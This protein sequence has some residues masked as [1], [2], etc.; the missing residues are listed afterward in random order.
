[1]GQANSVTRADLYRALWTE[2]TNKVAKNYGIS[3]VGL[4][5]ICRK[6]DIPRPPR[7]YWAQRQHGHEPEQIPLPKPE[8]NPSIDIH[9]SP[10]R[11]DVTE[12]LGA[13]VDIN[14]L[15]I[16]VSDTLRGCHELTSR[17][18][19][20]VQ[21]AKIDADG[22]IVPSEMKAMDIRTSKDNARRALLI[23]D[24]ILKE[25]LRHEYTVSAGPTVNIEQHAMKLGIH[26]IVDTKRE[27]DDKVDLGKPYEFG[28]SRHTTSR[29]PS[30]RLVLEITEGRGYWATGGRRSWRDSDKRQLE[31]QL[32]KVFLGLVETAAMARRHAEE[33]KQREEQ[34]QQEEARREEA[35]RQRAERYKQYRTEKARFEKLIQ[36]SQDYKESRMIR[37]LIEAVRT[38]HEANGPID[39]KS[40]IG[41]WIEWAVQQADRLDPLCPTPPSILDEHFEEDDPKPRTDTWGQPV[42]Q[43]GTP[44]SYWE[45]RGWWKRN[46]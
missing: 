46:R 41:R 8:H 34:R 19:D 9:E 6:H 11:V 16:H 21:R 12:A 14:S 33:E 18:N 35:A 39:A 23:F 45:R 30:G 38:K 1:M 22:I 7:G 10:P 37:D 32:D 13:K 4:A 29:V 3:D 25:C 43:H 20:E 27:L 44:K 15:N 24:A 26:E 17:A 40:E 42:Y 31:A 5:K 36:Q 28:H 2:P